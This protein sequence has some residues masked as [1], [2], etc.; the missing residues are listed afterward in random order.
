M[1]N[2]FLPESDYFFVITYLI[3]HF[4]VTNDHE[5]LVINL[6]ICQHM[7]LNIWHLEINQWIFVA[8]KFLNLSFG[9]LVQDGSRGLKASST[10]ALLCSRTL[11]SFLWWCSWIGNVPLVIALG[12]A[13]RDCS[14]HFFLRL[15]ISNTVRF[16]SWGFS[17]V[18][19]VTLKWNFEKMRNYF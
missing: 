7:L 6:Y 3:N 12:K 5:R 1:F 4:K 9:L 15:G 10:P 11:L 16:W 13:S 8:K 2:H 17:S 19:I 18:E 14:L